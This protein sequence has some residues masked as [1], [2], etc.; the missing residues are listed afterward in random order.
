VTPLAA[1][2]T[3]AW[4]APQPTLLAQLLRPLSWLFG[5]VAALRRAAY[6]HRLLPEARLPVP[7]IV[8]GNITVGGTG[9]T[10][11]VIALAEALRA[12]GRRP[13]IV[14]RGY[15]R[16]GH[17]VRAV[18]ID[19]DA[20]D[21]GDEALLLAASGAPTWIGADRAAAARALL[22]AEPETDVILA[23]DGMQHYALAR[24]VEIVV[25]DGSRDLG[26]R[27][28]LPA[29]P[30]REPPSRLAC[31]DAVVRLRATPA[32]GATE[33]RGR[34]RSSPPTLQPARP[35]SRLNPEPP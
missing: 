32:A 18:R 30:L 21:T 29:G 28:L 4:Y 24:D 19:D 11:L 16:A 12:R 26:N 31:V 8:V 34:A 9:K 22:S 15:G 1:V 14:S 10:P 6:R 20:R 23:D 2:L 33:N 35:P 5:G 7:V 27:L 25:I 17:G 3:R 13:G